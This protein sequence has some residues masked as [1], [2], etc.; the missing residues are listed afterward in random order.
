M[1]YILAALAGLIGAAA[2]WF[3]A[4]MATIVVGGWLGV[5]DFEGSRG[6]L[7]VWGIG[8]LGGLAG[9]IAGIWLMLRY[10]GGH[11]GLALSWRM[12]VVMLAAALIVAGV[13]WFLYETRPVL[14]SNGA[15]PRLAFEIRLP[16]QV[17]PPAGAKVEL[18]TDK[19]V[20][21]GAITATRTDGDRAVLAGTVEVY[22]RASWRI[23][24]L[25]QQGGP[26]RI[27]RLKL[28]ARPPHAKAFGD[29]QR[30]DDVAE[31][32]QV[33]KPGPADV[34]DVRYRVIW[35]GEE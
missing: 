17:P 13:L 8:P 34:Y 35:P 24:V 31:G 10:R 21:P 1:T 12:P 5:S 4:A 29:W 2:G 9:L 6:M 11:R 16:P 19:N 26:E 22:Y 23:L 25:K 3:V 14:N 20:M 7:A 27:F 30:V 28:A 33:R 18:Q 15:P 32:P